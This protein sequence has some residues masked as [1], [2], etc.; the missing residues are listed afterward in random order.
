MKILFCWDDGSPHD[1]QLIRL[2]ERY[3]IPGMFFIPTINKEGRP[4]ITD[5]DIKRYCSKYI[6]F[7]A[8]TNNH[9]YLTSIDKNNIEK[10]VIDNKKYLE[11]ITGKEIKH[12]CLPGGKYNN[13]ILK[14]VKKHFKTI[15]TA[16]TGCFHHKK[17]YLI[18]P[19]IHFYD[20]GYRSL[21]LNCMK[22]IEIKEAFYIWKHRKDNYFELL[23]RIIDF[24]SNKKKDSI[25]IVWGHSWEIEEFS[26][27]DKIE[28]LF[29][30]VTDNY[31]LNIIEY[32][33][34]CDFK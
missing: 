9:T 15:R 31:N 14:I 27:W 32:D 25:I 24:E 13:K 20:R 18:K 11:R 12:F 19:T 16:D 3:K 6:S 26:L 21:F 1:I 2:H 7:G 22:H 30:F 5:S 33:E 10:E 28:D 8:H 17:T 34:L 29:L 4:V 23:K